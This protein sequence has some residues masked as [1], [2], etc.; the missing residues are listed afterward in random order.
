MVVTSA[1]CQWHKTIRI[2]RLN[3]FV[4]MQALLYDIWFSQCPCHTTI[5]TVWLPLRHNLN[6]TLALGALCVCVCARLFN[7]LTPNSSLRKIYKNKIFSFSFFDSYYAKRFSS[8][9]LL[10]ATLYCAGVMLDVVMFFHAFV[11]SLVL[12]RFVGGRLSCYWAFDITFIG[13]FS[14]PFSANPLLID[15][16]RIGT[17][18]R[19]VCIVRHIFLRHVLI[20][21]IYDHYVFPMCPRCDHICALSV[22]CPWCRWI[23][24]SYT[25]IYFAV[26]ML[27]TIKTEKPYYFFFIRKTQRC[28]KST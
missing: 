4:C 22:S 17:N 16:I 23:L 21:S 2:Q 19:H 18:F 28:S 5:A 10:I 13:S 14:F 1:F 3:S 26:Q 27:R 15:S 24:K 7:R 11:G 20:G 9:H 6:C 25:Y 12:G 8:A